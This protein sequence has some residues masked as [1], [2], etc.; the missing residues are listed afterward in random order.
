M[1]PWRVE[2]IAADAG[3]FHDAPPSAGNRS[4]TFVEVTAP[5]LV[6]GSSQ[7]AG[8][9]RGD[10]AVAQGISVVR[11]RS[12]GGGVLL[13]PKE[14]VWLDL[15]IPA[16]DPLWDDDIGRSMWW[17]GELW[18]EGLGDFEP[19]AAVHRGALQRSHWSTDVCFAGVGPGEVMVGTAKLVG[20]SQRRTRHYARFQSMVHLQWR[21]DVVASLVAADPPAGELAPLVAL[22][23][24]S[25]SVVTTALGAAL[26]LR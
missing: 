12:G 17:V 18:R 13:L 9:V 16:G 7:P 3:A 21:P 5:T 8:S 19:R 15:V 14:F 1:P 23:A 25:A 22:C 6:L 20:V 2:H 26:A 10:A 11:R 24:A 4:A